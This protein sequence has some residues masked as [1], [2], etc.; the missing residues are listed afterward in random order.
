MREEQTFSSLTPQQLASCFESIL[1]GESTS[2]RN[3]EME[4]LR[5]SS[6]PQFMPILLQVP[7]VEG[8]QCTHSR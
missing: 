2:I 3:M 5:L 4:L 7:F 6:D 8:I 1:S